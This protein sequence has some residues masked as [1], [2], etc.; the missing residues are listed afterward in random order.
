LQSTLIESAANETAARFP[1]PQSGASA[2]GYAMLTS[3]IAAVIVAA[4]TGLGSSVN[5]EYSSVSAALK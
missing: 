5:S 2:I 4:V 3:G 1:P